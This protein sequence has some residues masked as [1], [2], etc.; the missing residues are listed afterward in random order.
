MNPWICPK[1]GRVWGPGV[2]ACNPCNDSRGSAG[3]EYPSWRPVMYGVFWD[4]DR[5]IQDPND[6]RPTVIF[7]SMEA[8]QKQV[9]S[10][11]GTRTDVYPEGVVKPSMYKVLPLCVALKFPEQREEGKP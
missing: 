4:T 9:V 2:T 6:Y 8:A 1:C 5:E 7:D 10:M 3:A 11:I